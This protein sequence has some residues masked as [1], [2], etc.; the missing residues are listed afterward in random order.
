MH[1]HDDHLYTKDSHK[2]GSLMENVQV[3]AE[4]LL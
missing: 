4:D 1:A 3:H 2:V